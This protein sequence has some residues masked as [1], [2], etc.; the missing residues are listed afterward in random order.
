MDIVNI[1]DLGVIENGLKDCSHTVNSFLLNANN[2]GKTL[3]F[4][5][6]CYYIKSG[7]IID[8]RNN[9]GLKCDNKTMFYTGKNTTAITILNMNNNQSNAIKL[10]GLHIEGYSLFKY[11]KNVIKWYVLKK[12]IKYEFYLHLRGEEWIKKH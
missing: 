12:I 3:Y 8:A 5:K 11:I 2:N 1:K 10:V 4:P 7:L 9:I 6:G